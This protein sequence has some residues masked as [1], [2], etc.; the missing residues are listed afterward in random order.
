LP[1]FDF[2]PFL[3][4][5]DFAP[6]ASSSAVPDFVALLLP[7]FS[8]FLLA[9]E[10]VSV[11]VLVVVPAFEA[12]LPVDVPV[13]LVPVPVLV[14]VDGVALAP[15][16]EDEEPLVEG[17]ALV[18]ERLEVVADGF[19]DVEAEAVGL[20]LAVAEGE[21]LALGEAEAAG[22]ADAYGVMLAAGDALGAAVAFVEAA[23]PV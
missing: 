16:E 1:F 22:V 4:L 6:A 3:L 13:A 11:V 19:A 10:L 21:A 7:A 14:L 8:L 17:V 23:T 5:P 18:L 2:S 9:A 12:P 20:A 15:V